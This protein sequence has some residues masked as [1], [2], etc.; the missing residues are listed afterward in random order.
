M[1]FNT[2]E[3]CETISNS[4]CYNVTFYTFDKDFN[5]VKTSISLIIS[6]SLIGLTLFLTCVIYMCLKSPEDQEY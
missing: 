2:L 3:D 4:T 6:M 1:Y 5:E